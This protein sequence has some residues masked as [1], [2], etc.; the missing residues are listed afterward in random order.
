MTRRGRLAG[1]C[2]GLMAGACLALAWGLAARAAQQSVFRSSVD[3]VVVDVSVFSSGRPVGDLTT[4]D[5]EVRDK[6]IVQAVVDMSYETLPIDVTLVI[7]VSGSV[8]GP[9]LD[10]LTRAI[11]GVGT[12]LRPGDRA[13]PV[14]FND[15]IV[16][17]VDLPIVAGPALTAALN[18][19]SGH[20]TLLDAIAMALI[21]EPQAGRRQLAIVF[22][23]GRDNLSILNESAVLDVARRSGP[24]VFVVAA[25][26]GT[27]SPLITRLGVRLA[28]A[29]PHEALFRSLANLTGGQFAVLFRNQDLSGSFVQAFD[30][31]RTS[32]V[33]R[34]T[35][36][37]VP[38]AGWHDITVQVTR[39]GDYEIRARKGYFGDAGPGVSDPGVSGPGV[40][41]PGV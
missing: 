34:Y 31:F 25:T 26:A 37:G 13:R 28:T 29:V 36:Q 4:A 20:T 12:R 27:A 23:D 22:T 7:D 30:A 32:Y 1:A 21:A 2:R 10:A 11:N 16:E 19:T 24:S 6:G 39:P 14:T 5:F 17:H 18:S 15:R 38:R 33:L 41:G 8:T 35:V 9:L 40:S 3:S